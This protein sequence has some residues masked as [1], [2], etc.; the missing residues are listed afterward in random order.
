MTS[1]GCSKPPLKRS[2]P[3][4]Q[5][6]SSIA[7]WEHAESTMTTTESAAMRADAE[8]RLRELH[9][10]RDV[11]WSDRDD[12]AVLSEITSI[13]SQITAAQQALA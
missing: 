10:V 5:P 3:R 11:L 4:S 12:P 8:L 9:A 1:P 6:D 2:T 7:S 13:E